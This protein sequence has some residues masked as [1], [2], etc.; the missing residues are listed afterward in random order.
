MNVTYQVA[1]GKSNSARESGLQIE[2]NGAVEL[3]SEQYLAFDRPWDITMGFV[4]S[5]DSTFKIRGKRIN[6]LRIF[7]SINYV[8]GFRYTP[9][10][11]D[12][13]NS[14]GRPLFVRLDDRYL[15]EV[16][17]HWLQSDLKISKNFITGEK[18]GITVSIEI[19]NLLN[20]KNSVIVNP[21]T[22]EAYEDGDDVPNEWRD[23]RYIGPQEAG[24]PPTN[25]ARYL[26]P[27]QILYGISFKF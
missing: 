4:F 9:Y 14:L 20:I 15:D 22:G 19:R 27:R 8:S 5:T 10:E 25:P 24:V 7:A 17:K 2:Q 11:Q 12:G 1:R 21:I 18:T 3:S 23:P 26:S 16:S 13:E 6:G